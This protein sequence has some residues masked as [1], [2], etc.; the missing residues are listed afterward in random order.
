MIRFEPL[1]ADAEWFKLAAFGVAFVIYV[2]NHLVSAARKAQQRQA[3]RPPVAAEQPASPA[4]QQLNDELNDFL[5]KAGD[6]RQNAPPQPA[7][8]PRP[9]NYRSQSRKQKKQ[10]APVLDAQVVEEPLAKRKVKSSIVSRSLD[11]RAQ[12]LAHLPHVESRLEQQVQQKFAHK[13][14]H[15]TGH[16]EP[17]VTAPTTSTVHPTSAPG[18]ARLLQVLAN[19]QNV[20]DAI[21]LGEILQRP[22]HRW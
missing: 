14:G 11:Q 3:A 18:A 1:L 7:P 16:S 19:P 15:L 8:Q 2:I 12:S 22:E 9:A 5:R 21:V 4:R 6:K 10:S 13:V 17:I 20:R